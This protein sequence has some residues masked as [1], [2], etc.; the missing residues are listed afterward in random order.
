MD[1]LIQISNE[2]DMLEKNSADF[3]EKK[4]KLK[5]IINLELTD[6][7]SIIDENVKE[8]LERLEKK[9]IN[10]KFLK[11]QIN[12][13]LINLNNSYQD[14]SHKYKFPSKLNTTYLKL[15]EIDNTYSQN[16]EIIEK[17]RIELKEI[18]EEKIKLNKEL[19]TNTKILSDNHK[20]EMNLLEIKAVKDKIDSI[21]NEKD[22]EIKNIANQQKNVN[23]LI[24]NI[25]NKFDKQL[26]SNNS[27]KLSKIKNVQSKIDKNIKKKSKSDL[28]EQ[29]NTRETNILL[30]TKKSLEDEFS[31]KEIYI[32]KQYEDELKEHQDILTQLEK[33]EDK[34]EYEYNFSI[35]LL[36][37]KVKELEKYFTTL[38]E[39]NQDILTFIFNY[40]CQE[41]ILEAKIFKLKNITDSKIKK[42]RK[43]IIKQE[44]ISVKNYDSF[45]SRYEYQIDEL[46]IK[47]MKLDNRINAIKLRINN[48]KIGEVNEGLN[49]QKKYIVSLLKKI[50]S[51]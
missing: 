25:K 13:E 49:N 20:K 46:K 32:I 37:L 22:N 42:I 16:Q 50:N 7:Q 39:R 36:K 11:K 30:A 43:E 8:E 6:I 27:E 19:E 44:E 21:M 48:I 41:D 26:K 10:L 2:I 51:I 4:E 24:K 40:R 38:F 45:Q 33:D 14:E 34:N 28:E 5:T 17:T 15:K 35:K 18:C 12:H 3:N 29:I 47:T 1:E 31:K 23:N 9:S